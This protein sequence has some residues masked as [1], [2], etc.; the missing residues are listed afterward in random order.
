MNYYLREI[1]QDHTV[2][3]TDSRG[4]RPEVVT[5]NKVVREKRRKHYVQGGI[6]ALTTQIMLLDCLSDSGDLTPGLI[7]R[8]VLRDGE[9]EINDK[10]GLVVW[11]A[12]LL[13]LNANKTVITVVSSRASRFRG[14]RLEQVMRLLYMKKVVLWPFGRSEIHGSLQ[15]S[16]VVNLNHK[17]TLDSAETTL[18]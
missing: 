6:Y 15:H 3:G 7:S 17:L 2:M 16:P 14:D 18:H 4:D 9:H 8:V 10:Y 12:T 13:T 1:K 5:L 11:L